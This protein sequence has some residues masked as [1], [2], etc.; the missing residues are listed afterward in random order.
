MYKRR[1]FTLVELLVVIAIIGILVA[2]LLPAVQSAREA[3]R[4][5][6]CTNK[7]KQIG[8]AAHTYHDSNKSFP[9]GGI[10][11]GGCCGTFSGMTWSIALLPNLEAQALFD[12]YDDTKFNESLDNI[13]VTR[14]HPPAYKC[15][16]EDE[17]DILYPVGSGPGTGGGSPGGNNW[18]VRTIGSGVNTE[19]ARGS[20]RACSGRSNGDGWWDNNQAIDVGI[21]LAWRGAMHSVGTHGMTTER[22]DDIVDG[23]SNTLLVGEMASFPDSSDANNDAP[24][25][26]RTFWAYTYTSYNQ[27]TAVPQ[28]RAFLV[29]YAKCVQIGGRGGSN[30]CKRGWGSY[31]PSGINFV[32]CDGSTRFVRPQTDMLLFVTQASIE[33]GQEELLEVQAGIANN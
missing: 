5:I 27:S 17:T 23:T 30:P 33:G 32:F 19:W 15:P 3:A 1:A 11:E 25:R 9:M 21:P 22:I 26:R 14:A 18:G 12:Q 4:R 20:Y 28:S 10:T 6:Q 2:L 29:D 16:S 24:Q 13:A 31:H 8:L 7:L